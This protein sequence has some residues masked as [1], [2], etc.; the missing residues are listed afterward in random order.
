MARPW[1][2]ATPQP[3][4]KGIKVLLEMTY[5]EF[6][7]AVEPQRRSVSARL[8]DKGP[9]TPGMAKPDRGRR[10]LMGSRSALR[11]TEKGKV[12]ST[13]SRGATTWC[14]AS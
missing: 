14:A 13:Q 1:A 2:A 12:H 8:G 4:G 3:V 9:R 5:D 11:S 7:A 10:E 6:H